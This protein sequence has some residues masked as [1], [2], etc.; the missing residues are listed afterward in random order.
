[1]KSIKGEYNPDSN[2]ASSNKRSRRISLT[3]RMPANSGS[4]QEQLL[5]FEKNQLMRAS[6]TD[7]KLSDE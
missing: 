1:M 3:K 2:K 5:T 7:S 6:L 4:N